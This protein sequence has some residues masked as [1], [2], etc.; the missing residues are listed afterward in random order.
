[1]A[2]GTSRIV[3]YILFAFFVS[4]TDF[5]VAKPLSLTVIGYH[6]IILCFLIINTSTSIT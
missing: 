1:M 3:R 6:D 2:A 4:R 5:V